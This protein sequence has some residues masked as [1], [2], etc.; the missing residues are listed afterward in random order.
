MLIMRRIFLDTEFSDLPWSGHSEL[1]WV[2]LADQDGRSWSAVSA[3]VST[4]AHLSEFVRDV[5]FH[6]VHVPRLAGQACPNVG[7]G[8]DLVAT[9]FGLVSPWGE[10]IKETA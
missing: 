10:I 1:L 6:V 2:G 8:L 9:A 3:E 4:E 5:G 7:N